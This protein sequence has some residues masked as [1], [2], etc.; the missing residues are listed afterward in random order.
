MCTRK[1]SSCARSESLFERGED[2]R[3]VR[4]E[5]LVL[6]PDD[7]ALVQE[8]RFLLAQEGLPIQEV[9]PLSY[10]KAASLVYDIFH[11]DVSVMLG[12]D[13]GRLGIALGSI[14]TYIGLV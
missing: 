11:I 6:V 10:K 2:L 7:R 4:E 13:L 14:Q 9:S 12:S 5:D 3:L 1:L 8:E